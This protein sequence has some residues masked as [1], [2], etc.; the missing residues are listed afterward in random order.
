MNQITL[1]SD[2]YKP[3]SM[4]AYLDQSV[5]SQLGVFAATL[6]AYFSQICLLT[7]FLEQD[8][9]DQLM[10]LKGF[11]A[12][13]LVLTLMTIGFFTLVYGASLA[14]W[15]AAQV[16]KGKA[17]LPQNRA[18]VL[19]TTLWTLPFGFLVLLV[20]S[21]IPREELFWVR[22]FLYTLMALSWVYA[23]IVLIKTLSEINRFGIGRALFTAIAGSLLLYGFIRVTLAFYRALDWI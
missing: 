23:G 14:Y 6:L 20:I 13:V 1:F 5:R 9:F 19:W 16:V 10:T 7:L 3:R 2:W 22:I 12:G 18:A 15:T 21:T 11:F 17:S 8:K 4:V